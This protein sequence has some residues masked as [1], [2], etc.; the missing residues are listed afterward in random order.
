MIVFALNFSRKKNAAHPMNIALHMLSRLKH[1]K[2]FPF[3]PNVE[4]DTINNYV[5]EV[6]GHQFFPKKFPSAGDVIPETDFVGQ[7]VDNVAQNLI[8]NAAET[9]DQPIVNLVEDLRRSAK[10]AESVEKSFPYPELE[11]YLSVNGSPAKRLR[12]D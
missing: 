11:R 5:S 7:V 2:L 10:I 1:F 9:V 6:S 3:L 8:D 4:S 12:I